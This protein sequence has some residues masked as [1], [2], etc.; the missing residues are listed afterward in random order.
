MSAA[1]SDGKIAQRIADMHTC[2]TMGV[3]ESIRES[4]AEF[5]VVLDDLAR[6]LSPG[7]QS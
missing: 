5:E 3:N 1:D 6:D 2:L 7:E 4:A